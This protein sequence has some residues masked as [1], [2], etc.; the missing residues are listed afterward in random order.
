MAYE[1]NFE[2]T[3]VDAAITK[4]QTM[5][6]FK[7]AV[8]N[9]ASL[10]GSPSTA[11]VVLVTGASTGYDAGLY[12]YSGSA[13]VYM[14]NPRQDAD[15]IDDTSTTHKFVTQGDLT[16]L[17]NTSG[18]NTGDQN[19]SSYQ[20]QPSEGPFV[21]GNKTKLDNIADNADVTNTSTVT[22]AGAL[23]DSEVTNLAQVKAFASSDYATAAQG[24]KADSALQSV[25]GDSNPTLAADLDLAT[26]DIVTESSDRPIDLA[27]HGTGGVV[28]RGNTGSGSDTNI[29]KITFNCE[30]NSHGVTIQGPAHSAVSGGGSYTLTLPAATGSNKALIETN[31]SGVLTFTNSPTLTTP[32][33]TTLD[34]AGAIQEHAVNYASVS[35]STALNAANGTIQ[36]WVLS[37]AV[38]PTDSLSDGEAITLVIDD[39]SAYAI[40]WGSL[41]IK[42]I[43]GSA[44][45]LDATNETLIVIWQLNNTLYGMSPGVLS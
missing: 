11:D 29:G 17:S 39:G 34:M 24:V 43:G 37:G 1:S 31:G 9:Y 16:T 35:G 33:V 19:L 28:L 4:S 18:T 6:E 10:P 45:S 40:S 42:W 8:A 26:F 13:W 38:T 20:L 23:M 36:R 21:N 5:P 7:A 25:A 44:P 32:V 27:P 30:Q 12:R 3:A 15:D 14:G 2:G 22:A 41:T